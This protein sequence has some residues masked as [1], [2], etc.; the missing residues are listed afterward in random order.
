MGEGIFL[1]LRTCFHPETSFVPNLYF[2]NGNTQGT[3]VF[4][5]CRLDFSVSF[6]I[7]MRIVNTICISKGKAVRN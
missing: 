4:H 7:H 3:I 5:D 1:D 2:C 6:M